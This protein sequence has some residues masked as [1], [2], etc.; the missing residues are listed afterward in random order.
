MNK[1]VIRVLLVEDD[2]DDYLLT[3]EI[4][5]DVYGDRV[6]TEWVA[7]YDA[8][9]DKLKDTSHDVYLFDYRLGEHSGLDLLKA[10]AELA[11]QEPIILLTGQGSTELGRE[12][13]RLGAADYLVKESIDAPLLE[14]AI[15]FAIQRKA[16]QQTLQRQA[17][18]FN[19]IHDTVFFTDME[20]KIVDWNPA[21]E[22]MSGYSKAEVLGRIPTFL[23]KPEEVETL[24]TVINAGLQQD[25]RWTGEVSYVRKDGTEGLSQTVVALM[26]DERGQPTGRLNTSH[27]ITES[28]RAEETLHRH[29]QCQSA[30]ADL[31]QR[32]LANASIAD[33]MQDATELVTQTLDIEYSHVLELLPGSTEL[34]R[35]AGV[36]WNEGSVEKVVVGV[37]LDS[38]AGYA[39]HSSASVLVQDL[40]I[41]ARFNDAYLLEEHGVLSGMSVIIMGKTGPYGVLGAYSTRTRTFSADE[42]QFLQ[43]MANTLAVSVEKKGAEE[44]LRESEARFRLMFA[45]NPLPMWVYDLESLRFLEVNEASVVRY[46]Y[47]R[48]EFLSMLITDIR[49]VEELP[50]LMANLEQARPALQ[51]SGEWRHQ[52]KASQII[53]M[54]IT[55]HSF[56][57]GGYERNKASILV[58][59]EDITERKHAER[60][61]QESREGFRQAFDNAAIGMA[62]VGLDGAWLRVNPSIC[63]IVGYSESELRAK[64]FQDIT[65]PDD[66]KSDLEHVQKMLNNEISFYNMEK[67][68]FHKDGHIVWVFLSV[69]LVRD[70]DGAPLY[71][72]S[73]IQDITERRRAEL[74]LRES[75]RRLFQYLEA[76]PVGV[77]VLDKSGSPYFANDKAKQLLGKGIS[78]EISS[79]ELG[80]TYQAYIAGTRQMYPSH[81]MPIV[82]ALSGEK[83]KIADMEV[84]QR[85]RRVPLEV[86]A[87]PIY[88]AEGEVLYAIAVF[89]DITERKQAEQELQRSQERFLKAFNASPSA[90]AI[91]RFVGGQFMDMNDSFVEIFGYS[92]EELMGQKGVDMN[93][94]MGDDTRT[95][96][97]KMLRETGSVRQ[98]EIP[99]RP[100]SEAIINVLFSAEVIYLE[101]EA[102]LLSIIV[103][104]TERKKAEE[105]LRLSS[106]ILQRVN[107]LVMVSNKDGQITYASPSVKRMLGYEPQ[108]LLSDG[109]WHVSMTDA[110]E[111]EQEITRLTDI[112]GSVDGAYWEPYER[113]VLDHADELHCILWQD[114]KGP[115]HSII[116]VGHDITERKQMQAAHSAMEAAKAA[117]QAKSEFLSRM[118]HELRTP[119]NAIIGFSQLL[120]MDDLTPDQ[121]ES[122]QLVH[123]AGRHLLDLINEVL[124][125]SHIEAGRMSIS[126]EPV[127]VAEVLRECLDL[128]RPIAADK[129]IIV[130]AD[131][132]LKCNSCVLAD[133]QRL[134]QIML[135]LLSNSVKYNRVGGSVRL[136]CEELAPGQV[137][138]AVNDTGVGIAQEKLGKLFTP[139]ERL[140][141]DQTGVEGTGLGLALSK[142]L[143]VMMGGN[144]GVESVVG[145]GSTFWVEL[146]TATYPLDQIEAEFVSPPQLLGEYP[147]GKKVLYIEDNLSNLRLIERIFQQ[148]PDTKLLTAMQVSIG[149][150]LAC[151]HDPDLILLDLH[152]PD[153]HGEKVLEW[154]RQDPRTEKTPVI[155]ISADATPREATRLL[156]LGANT[157]ITKPI[158]VKHLVTVIESS[159]EGKE[160]TNAR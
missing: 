124:E 9:L 42:V 87:A 34:L 159:L 125:I 127:L 76:M 157:Y 135:N 21:A 131:E 8:A 3:S 22:R 152:L 23:Q 129:N 148:W 90:I 98:L 102:C 65:H 132:A 113:M 62:L 12:A 45:N 144:T 117:D 146:P 151:K 141:A 48:D 46:G 71:F 26:F 93:I 77:F 145:Q 7:N 63:C 53:D 33:L 18:I 55:S 97:E 106:E 74:A 109:W 88:D 139:F 133:R 155:I 49:P 130:A 149:F 83:S 30:I 1:D 2:K 51:S 121:M 58:V 137:R 11:I 160:L 38:Q 43:A 91:N 35:T 57:F 150:E 138:I 31:G 82:R 105:A 95:N 81:Q 153:V 80:N 41:D 19:S 75:E 61:L 112:A 14:R 123:K 60:S 122:I 28:R 39:L 6:A 40:R 154:L 13:V 47:S 73:Q 143:A 142:H 24:A 50:R 25:G 17:L 64:T 158:D 54:Q 10:A 96:I 111:R 32:A 84:E 147:A 5:S 36:G 37:G 66:L 16:I 116:G 118:S 156:D 119:L 136:S 107:S 134:R 69:S 20:G 29:A 100:R 114:A 15:R 67:R 59:A 120:E 44:A 70:P 78:P 85:D 68:Y 72:I 86:T 115:G 103:D 128:V 99:V 104:I 140:D 126:L 52:T 79:E 56:A 110:G 27:D 4:L 89:N 94:L 108:D 92:R 101:G